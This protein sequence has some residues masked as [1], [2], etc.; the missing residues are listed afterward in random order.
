MF[1]QLFTRKKNFAPSW[2]LNY[3]HE[4]KS[5]PGIGLPSENHRFVIVDTETTGLD[6]TKAVLLS[7]AAFGVSRNSLTPEDHFSC[8]IRRQQTPDHENI[9]IHGI[10]PETSRAGIPEREAIRGFIEYCGNAIIVGHH[11]G[12]DLKHLNNSLRKLIPGARVKN[13]S[14]DIINLAQKLDRY[15]NPVLMDEKAYSL[16]QLCHRFNVAPVE[17]HTAEGD[18]WVTGILFLKLLKKIKKGGWTKTRHLIR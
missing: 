16:D 13:K 15:P 12:F 8:F 5:S 11:I 2:W 4:L 18:A 7:I 9:G 14:I 17:R 6:P 10:M 1:K 3:L